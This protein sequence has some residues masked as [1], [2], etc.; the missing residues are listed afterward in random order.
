MMMSKRAVKWLVT[1]CL[2]SF[3]CLS[4][5]CSASIPDESRLRIIDLAE[6]VF[7]LADNTQRVCLSMRSLSNEVNNAIS[8][9]SPLTDV[10]KN[11]H[12]IGYLEGFIIDP[13]ANDIILVGQRSEERPSLR[14][15][16]LV[17]NLR[18]RS[19]VFQYAYCSLDPRPSD[20]EILDSL[21][22]SVGSANSKDEMKR[23]YGKLQTNMGPQQVV[24]DGVPEN[25]RYAHIM[26]DA[27]YHMKKMSQGHITHPGVTSYLE[28]CMNQINS[29]Q[30]GARSPSSVGGMSRFWFSV[31]EIGPSFVVGDNIVW[32]RDC[33]IVLLTEKQNATS[34]GQLYDV[35]TDD[36]LAIE[37]ARSFTT[38]FPEL[39]K[40][41][42]EYADLENLYRLEAILKSLKMHKS[43]SQTGM[44]LNSFIPEYAYQDE[45]VMPSS[46]PG[47]TNCI[48]RTQ[49]SREGNM[50]YEEYYFSMVCGGVLMKIPILRSSFYKTNNSKL[51][52]F[53]TNALQ[54]RP[55]IDTLSW[56]VP[57]K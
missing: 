2:F 57:V 14:L 48:D 51:V 31:D 46:L 29:P 28:M 40:E 11:L 9:N 8:D 45:K 18:K 42:P 26:I 34:E 10:M 41:I 5:S 54:A 47:L 19:S 4:T 25:S 44:K 24:V 43:T 22:R 12:G 30:P 49:R 36:P 32:L 6:S 1:I 55:S 27:D 56:V 23:I 35:D 38:K 13:D 21:F 3:L 37:F 33:P 39:A 53:K 16:D 7:S 52:D 50:I 15:D 17:L 20:V